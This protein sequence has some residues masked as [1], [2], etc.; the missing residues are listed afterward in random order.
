MRDS[1]GHLGLRLR[2]DAVIVRYGEARALSGQLARDSYD[3]MTYYQKYDWQFLRAVVAVCP[4]RLC[5]HPG[6]SR[7]HVC[8]AYVASVPAHGAGDSL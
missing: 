4:P 7:G 6:P 5:R 3:C 8:C 1:D 2:C